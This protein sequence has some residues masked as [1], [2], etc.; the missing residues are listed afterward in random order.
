MWLAARLRFAAAILLATLVVGC[1]SQGRIPYSAVDAR[2]A[3]PVGFDGAGIRAESLSDPTLAASFSPRTTGAGHFSYLALSG[4]GGDGAYGAGILNGWSASGRRPVFSIVS[5]VSTGAIIAPFAFLG[6][7]YD[8]AL[9]EVY[10]N[11]TAASLVQSPNV[12]TALFGSGLFG[13]RRLLDLISQYVTDD[14]V[15]AIAREHRAG[16]RLFVLTTNID[17]QHGVVWNVGAIAASGSPGSVD[18]IRK[19]IAA[20]ASVPLAFSPILID[21]QADGRRFQEMHVDGSVATA[22]FILPRQFIASR[23][24]HGLNGGEIYVLMNT[25]IQPKFSVV[26]DKTIDITRA[27]FETLMTQ[28]TTDNLLATYAF[29]KANHIGFN[30]TAIDPSMDVSGPQSFDTQHM[31]KLFDVGYQ[32]AQTGQFWLGKPPSVRTEERVAER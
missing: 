26:D 2:N 27:S 11:G 30:L 32:T 9:R 28:K 14:M 15:A 6:P 18:L 25:S 13:N 1:A 4:G 24:A 12:V 16:R 8:S 10:T 29:A 23:D 19:V 20:S 21:V 31:R 3:V 5:G 22:V 17:S 7:D